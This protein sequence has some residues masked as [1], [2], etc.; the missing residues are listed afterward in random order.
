M[1][2]AE[3]GRFLSRDPLTYLGGVGL[4]SYVADSPIVNADPSGTLQRHTEVVSMVPNGGSTNFDISIPMESYSLWF[5]K[6]GAFAWS[7]SFWKRI[8]YSP[9]NYWHQRIEMEFEVYDCCSGNDVT[10]DHAPSHWQVSG[11]PARLYYDEA[12]PIIFGGNGGYQKKVG[13]NTFHFI[14]NDH[15]TH[16]HRG[17]KTWGRAK[18]S[19]WY[20]EVQGFIPGDYNSRVPEA[21][22]CASRLGQS[23]AKPHEREHEIE[24]KW[25]CCD[26]R[27]QC[28]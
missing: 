7:V 15:F 18:I 14:T 1:Y 5:G 12:L 28:K 16:P 8:P 26:D 3:L 27:S 25:C 22:G 4:Q 9:P 21:L 13:G 11:T 2:A 17:D 24:V 23:V 6:C 20:T 19:G 10:R